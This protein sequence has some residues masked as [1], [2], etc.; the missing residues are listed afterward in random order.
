MSLS[1]SESFTKA[2]KS[3]RP[4]RKRPAPFP[5][6]FSADERAYLEW[7]AGNKPIGAYIRAKALEGFEAR[8][9]K[10]TR[11]PSTDYAM[12]G[13]VLGMLG[14]LEQAKHLCILAAAAEA[15]RLDLEEKD[16]ADLRGACAAVLDMRAML[17]RALGLRSGG[18]P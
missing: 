2:A 5:V 7:K 3:A 10:P 11:A 16:R 12:L 9:R 1:A 15:G 18:S 13:Q 8:S 4:K 17:I 14:K 6:R